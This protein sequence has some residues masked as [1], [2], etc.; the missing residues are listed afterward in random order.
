[1]SNIK[2]RARR[3]PSGNYTKSLDYYLRSWKRIARPII[4]QTGWR[5]MAFDPG[6]VFLDN[7]NKTVNL[8]TQQ[9]KDLF[10]NN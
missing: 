8:T 2:T 4:K 9:I 5:L 7:N 10:K 3:L 1:M 6:F